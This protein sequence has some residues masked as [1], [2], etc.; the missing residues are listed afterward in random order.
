MEYIDNTSTLLLY[1]HIVPP[2][3]EGRKVNGYDVDTSPG[4]KV[5]SYVLMQSASD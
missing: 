3:A 1:I 2:K 5:L 4:E